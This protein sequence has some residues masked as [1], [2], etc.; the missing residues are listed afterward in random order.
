[1][2]DYKTLDFDISPVG[3]S[4]LEG[5]DFSNLAFGKVFLDHMFVMDYA[6]GEWK[7]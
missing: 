6:D 2:E 4:R 3:T 5:V 7:Q 1:M